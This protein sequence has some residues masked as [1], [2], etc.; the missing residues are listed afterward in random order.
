VLAVIRS[1]ST[2]TNAAAIGAGMAF[3]AATDRPFRARHVRGRM[4]AAP[5]AGV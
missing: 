1:V 5:A 2:P 4:Y 3:G